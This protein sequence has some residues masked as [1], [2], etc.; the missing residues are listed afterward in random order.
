[1]IR[2]QVRSALLIAATVLGTGAAI[3]NCS[4]AP[5]TQD[6]VGSV[7]VALTLSPGVTITTVTYQ[8]TGNGITPINGSIDVTNATTATA[9]VPGIPSNP[10]PYTVTMDAT[11]TDGLTTCHGV[12][13]FIVSANQTAMAGV[14]L[15]CHGPA[16]QAGTVA[17]NG[18]LDNC[19]TINSFSAAALEARAGQSIA[20]GVSASDLDAADVITYS[21]TVSPAGIG[22]ILGPTS[23][24][25]AFRCDTVG[26]VSISISI[27]DGVCGDARMNAIPINCLPAIVGVGGMGVGGQGTGG[28]GTGG[29]GVGGMGTGGMGVG[30]AGTGGT[31]TGGTIVVMGTGGSMGTGGMVGPPL[32]TT[33]AVGEPFSGTQADCCQCTSDNCS[34]DPAP[35]GT[36]GCSGISNPGDQA[37]CIAVAQCYAANSAICTTAGDPTNCFCGTNPL[38]CFSTV[39]AANGPC[40][41]QV[42]AAAKTTDPTQIKMQ[43]I[44]PTSPL[45]RA[46][47]LTT[48][49]GSFCP[50][51][52]A[53]H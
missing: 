19:P 16:S 32:C 4:R 12:G 39:G 50:A 25:T 34:L 40:S 44:S 48:C 1:M 9:L 42:I 36:D 15:Q 43:F 5:S 33:G 26:Q 51:E 37:L 29:M 23:A 3:V 21:W 22:T 31:G 2:T 41:A 46:T 10:N 17:I 7:N 28:R 38:T 49:R 6:T 13:T 14:T 47:N 30:G 24:N 27:S 11:S 20:I 52:C 8:I 53:I 35:N 18:R 45:G